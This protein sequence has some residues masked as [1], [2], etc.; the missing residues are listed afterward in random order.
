MASV[1]LELHFK[2]I[3]YESVFAEILIRKCLP[4]LMCGLDTA[5]LDSTSIKLVT[6]VWNY[7]FRWLYGEGKFTFTR[8]LF[9]S[10]GT[11]SM[12]FLLHCNIL[13]LYA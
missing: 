6:Q 5:S 10:H 3:S 8:H 13:S 1:S 2:S 11:K 4:V 12:R 9:D 7:T